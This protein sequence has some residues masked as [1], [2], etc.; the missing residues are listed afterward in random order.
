MAAV[1]NCRGEEETLP[2]W[3]S[4]RKP[5]H[6]VKSVTL[7][8]WLRKAMKQ[9]GVDLNEFK[10]HSVRS[11]APAH[12]RKNKNLSMAQILARGGWKATADGSSRTFLRFYEKVAR[13]S[14]DIGALLFIIFLTY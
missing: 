9:G 12:F 4:S 1:A 10:A 13:E 14:Q 3:Q 11:A 7:A 5:Y 2:L 6:Q 8:G